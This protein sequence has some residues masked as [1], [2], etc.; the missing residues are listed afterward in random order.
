VE[1]PI[2]QQARTTV[3]VL[4]RLP[5]IMATTGPA[6]GGTAPD[7]GIRDDALASSTSVIGTG[8]WRSR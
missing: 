3:A 7:L 5:R 4:A 1:D 2:V 6:V 8:A